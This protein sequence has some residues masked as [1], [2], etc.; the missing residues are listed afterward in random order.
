MHPSSPIHQ[1]IEPLS[2]NF[3]VWNGLV[4]DLSLAKARAIFAAHQDQVL[5]A[6]GIESVKLDE[7]DNQPVS[8]KPWSF[9][10]CSTFPSGLDGEQMHA[11]LG[12]LYQ[13]TMWETP[14]KNNRRSYNSVRNSHALAAPLPFV[15]YSDSYGHRAYVRGVAK[16]G[17]G[18][19]LWT[20]ELRD[21][22][23]TEELYDG[24]R[25]LS[26]RPRPW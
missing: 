8:A 7:C 2:G 6:K 13:Q 4:P 21:A 15:L 24:W 11:L 1:A 17:F 20:P 22:G 10:E 3:L 14:K 19:L 25:P 9:P 12:T 23:S 26:S 18:G 16:S 5:F